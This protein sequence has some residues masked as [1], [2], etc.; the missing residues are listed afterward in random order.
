MNNGILKRTPLLVLVVALL[1]TVSSISYASVN[2]SYLKDVAEFSKKMSLST[3]IFR[4]S[5]STINR[6]A[7]RVD[8]APYTGRGIGKWQQKKKTNKRTR[9]R[10][11][12]SANLPNG[13]GIQNNDV[14]WKIKSANG[15]RATVHGKSTTVRLAPGVYQITLHIGSY[16]KVQKVTIRKSR[17]NAQSIPM[18]ARLGLLSI[19]STMNNK[20]STKKIRWVAKNRHGVVIAT[21]KGN[22]FRKL[23][24]AGRYRVEA[25]YENAKKEK[26]VT[27]KQGSVGRDVI[28]LP[29]GN[30]KI[31]AYNK[32]THEPIF[33][34]TR[35]VIYNKK[36]ES[37]VKSKKHNLRLT[38]FP[39]RYTAELS[40]KGKKTTKKFKVSSGRNA[41]VH[42]VVK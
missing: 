24:P 35:W 3:G 38:L 8:N 31:S 41:D 10:V 29:A 5:R 30:I 14:E 28:D 32:N 9:T 39:G 17:N 16:K 40:A 22:K 37:V 11:R 25:H 13:L 1:M 19:S 21:G 15:K 42:I 6:R 20:R 18:R 36:G 12:L 34:T 7:F 33:S 27:V 2:I 26:Y 4:G 23:V